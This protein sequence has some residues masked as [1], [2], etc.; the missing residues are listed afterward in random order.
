MLIYMSLL[1]G[2]QVHHFSSK[3]WT[4]DTNAFIQSEREVLW[5]FIRVCQ[6]KY[7]LYNPYGAVK[8]K[9]MALYLLTTTDN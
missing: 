1:S 4:L 3:T 5:V 7:V 8:P 9:S 2:Q 6:R